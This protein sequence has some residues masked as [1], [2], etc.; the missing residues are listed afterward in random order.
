M[1][2][3][4]M[5]EIMD[6]DA[7]KVT[8][9]TRELK[10]VARDLGPRQARFLVDTYYQ[11]Q[12]MRKQ[13]GNQIRADESE[14]DAPLPI[15]EWLHGYLRKLEQRI[16]LLMKHYSQGHPVGEWAMNIK[17]IGPVLSAGLLAHIDI[18]RADTAG[19]IWRFAGLDPTV[20]WEKGERRP[21]NAKLKTLCWKIGE[22]FV[23]VSGYEDAAYGQIYAERKALEIERN[24]TGEFEEQAL[25]RAEAN[26]HH[27]QVET[28]KDG[29]LPDSHIHARAKR[30]TVKLFLAHWHH[31][32]YEVH[33]GEEPPKPYIIEHGGHTHFIEP[34]KW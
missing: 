21:W 23:K 27:A 31:V 32:A 1:T 17:G 14:D 28:Y 7:L 19:S 22:S 5:Q 11:I 34:P 3:V 8:R 24:E 33:Y 18:T 30:Y 15:V 20:T 25:A 2:A 6:S 16:K 4:N 10:E 12:E 26:P 29:R 9:L 13:T